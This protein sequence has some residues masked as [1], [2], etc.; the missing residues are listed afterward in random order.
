MNVFWLGAA[1]ESITWELES[2]M[3]DSYPELFEAGKF[4]RTEI[5]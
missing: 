1:S 3:R 4:S 2:K 5:F